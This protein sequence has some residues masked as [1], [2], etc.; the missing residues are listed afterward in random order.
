MNEL[1][2]LFEY[3]TKH[4]PWALLVIIVLTWL[5]ADY[6]FIHSQSRIAAD[7]IKDHAQQTIEA[8][9]VLENIVDIL[10]EQRRIQSQTGM[11]ACLKEAKVDYERTDCVNKFSVIVIPKRGTR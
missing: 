6:G 1:V 4:G 2:K 9:K 5:A 11:L 7:A 3:I 10:D 8:Q